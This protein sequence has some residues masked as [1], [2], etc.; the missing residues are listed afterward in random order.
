MY[1]R[2]LTFGLADRLHLLSC[3]VIGPIKN[4]CAATSAH[5]TAEWAFLLEDCAGE[6]GGGVGGGVRK[7]S[8]R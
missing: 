5:I 2:A 4:G 3:G 6:S 8:P 7:T 1:C